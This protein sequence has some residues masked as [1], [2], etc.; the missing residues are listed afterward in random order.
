LSYSTLPDGVALDFVDNPVIPGN[1]TDLSGSTDGTTPVGE[2]PITISGATPAKQQ[3]EYTVYLVVEECD[4]PPM[5]VVSQTSFEITIT[6]GEQAGDETVFITNGATCGTLNWMAS[7][8]QDWVTP[9]PTSGS[10]QAGDEP[11]S[12]MTLEFNTNTLPEG[13]YTANI[14]VEEILDGRLAETITVTLHVDPSADSVWVADGGSV[15]GFPG[16]PVVV[17]VSFKNNEELA[18]MSLGLTWDDNALILDSVSY[19][20]DPGS[21]VGYVSNKMSVLDNTARTVGTGLWVSPG[22]SL[23]PPGTGHWLNLHFRVDPTATGGT[24]INI[25]T[26]F[27]ETNPGTGIELLF[28]D[29]LGAEILPQF[30]GG[31]VIIDDTPQIIAGFVEDEFGMPIEGAGVEL[32]EEFP[33]MDPPL[34]TTTTGPDGGF[35]FNVTAA[36]SKFGDLDT[37]LNGSGYVVRAYNASYYPDTEEAELQQQ[38]VLLVLPQDA[39]EVTPTLEWVDLYCLEAYFDDMLL[40]IGTV[41][42]AFDEPDGPGDDPVLCGEWVVSEV[43]KFGFMPVYTD[44]P[45]TTEDEGC[46]TNDVITLKVNGFEVDP[47]NA[48]LIWTGNGNRIEACFEGYSI[49][50]VCIDLLF[51]WNLISWNVDSEI[52]DVD[53]IFADVMDNV[54]VILGFEV[55]GLTYDP[56]LD[57]FSTLEETDHLHGFWVRMDAPDELCVEGLFVDP[58][59]PIELENNWNLVSYLPN[60]TLPTVDALVSIW[61]NLVVALGF[62]AAGVGA[63]TYDTDHPGMATLVD[64]WPFFGYW[65]KVD[66]AIDLVYPDGPIFFVS[67]PADAT[68]TKT[69]DVP[70]VAVSNTWINLYGSGVTV[71]GQPLAPNTVIQA[72]NESNTLV[73]EFVVESAG[74]F[75]F[76]P[77]YGNDTFSEGGSS[78]GETIRL[79]VDGIEAQETVTWTTNGDRIEIKAF[80]LTATAADDDATLPETYI[81]S[82]NYPN[83]FN[84]ETSIQYKL[85]EAGQVELAVY[86]VLGTRIKTLVS[87]YQ[88][89]GNYTVKWYGD[90]D[91]G[92]QVASGV[93]FYKLIAED[94]SETRKMMLLK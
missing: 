27:I 30:V 78:S 41:I 24:Q 90:T 44:D 82:Q 85:G 51:G 81:L 67:E 14:L 23:I 94:F 83:P 25:D 66:G 92:E 8:D 1:S 2:Y 48:P 15:T 9:D 65:L 72:V 29:S 13:D 53:S 36:S 64:M 46:D 16:L 7:S 89:A 31:S 84:P 60:D 11:G 28:S 73:G 58:M 6:Q 26:M 93:Y 10:V 55:G 5:V 34:Q 74:K 88:A 12:E 19:M 4:E 76:M 42:E 62:D 50:E 63:L 61:N 79:L 70:G 87:G 21:R 57:E 91:T 43:G 20:S 35:S 39:G 47:F 80:H 59:T 3:H 86:N 45:Y 33:S 22:E 75:G 49:I 32:Y 17:P 18:A 52:D 56:D 69:G 37:D 71:D 68:Y 77:V 40:P 54:D 38:D